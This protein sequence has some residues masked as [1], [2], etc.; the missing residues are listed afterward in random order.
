MKKIIYLFLLSMLATGCSDD[1][2]RWTNW[3]SWKAQDSIT[4]NGEEMNET[5]YENF[6]G[7]T[8]SLKNGDVVT[9]GGIEDVEG[10]LPDDF[11]EYAG[12]N[13]AKFT[14]PDGNYLLDYDPT[15][16]LLYIES[17]GAGYPDALWLCGIG[18]GH[19]KAGDVTTSGWSWA[20]PACGYYCKTIGEGRYQA[21][22]YLADGFNFKFFT[23]REWIDG[24]ATEI[25]ALPRDGIK[26]LNSLELSGH[27]TVGDFI[28]G[29]LFQPGVYTITLDMNERTLDAVPAD[30]HVVKVECKINGQL[31]GGIGNTP[32]MLGI[33]LELHNGDVVT[34]EKMGKPE[35]MVQPDYFTD[36]TSGSAKFT[37]EDG[38]YTLLYDMES[39]LLY[40]EQR[41][42]GGRVWVNGAGF[43]H[44]KWQYATA[45][46]SWDTPKSAI[47]AKTV[48]PGVVETTLYL[49]DGFHF[50]FFH[51]HDW[52]AETGS[53]QAFPYPTDMLDFDFAYD[54]AIGYGHFTGDFVQGEKFVPGVYTIRLDLNKR[55]C[56]L[57]GKVDE[58]VISN[59]TSING[60]ALTPIEYTGNYNWGNV[61]NSYLG[62]DINMTTGAEVQLVG[63][64]KPEK[65]MN[66][67]FFS[68]GEGH[69]TWKAPS[70]K[71]RF[72]YKK[73][74]GLTY[75]EP[76]DRTTQPDVIWVTG[77]GLGHPV[78]TRGR[79]EISDF[80]WTDPKNYFVLTGD[81]SGHYSARL[82]FEPNDGYRITDG[83]FFQ[84]YPVKGGWD[85]I[86]PAFGT[87]IVNQNG[88][89][90]GCYKGSQNYGGEEGFSC[91]VYL[92]EVD[93]NTDP[94]TI[95]FTRQ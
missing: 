43:A 16:Q 6:L 57:K 86:L 28:S 74:N 92:I 3:P 30:G 89:K 19:S 60:V 4:V 45:A 42:H 93:T 70:G 18:W 41:G 65:V 2:D 10:I 58:S 51:Q 15:R 23:I 50:K 69:I 47:M 1:I 53:L 77:L 84:F 91:G 76:V 14:G 40:V 68:V 52:G 59:T 22:L 33:E 7:K 38:T 49:T 56:M 17:P 54:E 5:V 37:G 13:S 34:F 81:G 78:S 82:F 32:S 26:L 88:A 95:T 44:P 12:G 11:F 20:N 94:A 66:P 61:T 63:F 29:P 46:W 87:T 79:F 48:A 67:D 8:M 71:Y 21:T 24:G 31:L 80:N 85:Y 64:P 62:A 75:I 25:T 39:K 9:F 27:T 90:I 83:F 55:A 36:C 73:D 72:S 35:Q